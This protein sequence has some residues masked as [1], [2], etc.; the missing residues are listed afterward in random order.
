MAEVPAAEVPQAEKDELFCAY[1]AM[2]LQDSELEI[3]ED[4]L[5]TLIKAAGGS[6]DA[7]FPTLFA[8]MCQGKDIES[9]LKFGGGG[10]GGGGGA[11]AAGGAAPA[12]GG[13]GA[14]KE[15]KKAVVEEEEEEEQ[16]FDL[17]G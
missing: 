6:I 9:M 16:D 1:A 4:K 12:A 17:F 13:G 15:E 2:I 14:A 3:S 5:N 11:P 7:F 10:G 8:K